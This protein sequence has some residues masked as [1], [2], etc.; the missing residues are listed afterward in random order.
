MSGVGMSGPVRGL[1]VRKG[2]ASERDDRP[3]VVPEKRELFLI[4]SSSDYLG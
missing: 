1:S 3:P 4:F 2:S